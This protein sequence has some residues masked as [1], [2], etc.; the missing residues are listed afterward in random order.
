MQAEQ[1]SNFEAKRKALLELDQLRELKHTVT[2][3]SVAQWTM[4]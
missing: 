3:I 4:V 1:L 2:L